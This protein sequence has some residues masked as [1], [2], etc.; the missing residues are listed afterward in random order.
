MKD[1]FMQVENINYI[2][3]RFG[4]ELWVQV[5]GHMDMNGANGVFWV[6]LIPNEDIGNALKNT[7]WEHEIGCISPG[8][9][10]YGHD[11]VE[12]DR[13]SGNKYE[14][15]LFLR[16]YAGIREEHIEISE[17][18]RLLNNLYFDIKENKYFEI[19]DNGEL[20]PVIKIE[21]GNV[22][23]K[24]NY[25]K[26]FATVKQMGIALYF[27]IRFDS[28]N[29]LEEMDLEPVTDNYF[30]PD[31][32]FDFYS[33]N[34][35]LSVRDK[36]SYSVIHGKKI[37]FGVSMED[38]GYWPF[39]KEKKYEDF[40]IGIDENGE[41]VR[42]TSNPNKLGNYFGT[43]PEAPH[44]L[45]PVYFTKDVLTKYYAK[46]ELYE[47]NDGYIRCQG[48]WLLR[49]DNLNKDY[50]SVYLGDLG[51]DLP[52]KEQVYWRS[53]NIIPDG[54]LSETKFRRDFLA[55]FADPDIVDMRFKQIFMSFRKKWNEKFGWDL[56]LELT[57]NDKYNFEHLRIPISKSQVEFDG[58][59]LSLV[60]TIIDSLNE[61][62]LN[63]L[64]KNKED[65][66][67]SISKLERFFEEQGV[68]GY[69]T[70]IKFL[71]NLQEL[72]STGSGHRKGRSYEKVCEK[73]N[74]R[75]GNFVE[76][77]EKI[78]EDSILFIEFLE[79]KFING[80]L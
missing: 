23:I 61:K 19:S 65:L 42:F 20:E 1:K 16:D 53:F 31:C 76:V 46:P 36:K 41:E 27:D 6:G 10:I 5:Y 39:E 13:F 43:N 49:I 3:N 59:I 44:Y 34:Y 14:P 54:K 38:C 48:L 57:E 17:E 25:L 47:V 69:E 12:Y 40:I 62:E 64:I 72:R 51:R 73:F 79:D 68:T 18:F 50:V 8:F 11:R 70:H 24:L 21:D 80:S 75:D 30:G 32:C 33:N 37:I 9:V 55:Q 22:Y 45:T 78:L 71:R 2:I 35:D 28:T 29:T 52:Y 77:F 74:L 56:F 67:G 26:R 60:K 66:K 4:K 63:K 7:N 58:L 15:L